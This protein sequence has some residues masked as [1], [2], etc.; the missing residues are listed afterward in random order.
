M[1]TV[2]DDSVDGPVLWASLSDKEKAVK[3]ACWDQLVA[4]RADDSNG[5][6]VGVVRESYGITRTK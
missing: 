5:W 2:T 1:S 4:D 6:V 3:T